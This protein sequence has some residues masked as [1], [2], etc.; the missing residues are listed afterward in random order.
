MDIVPELHIH[1]EGSRASL[2]WVVFHRA[3]GSLLI[4]FAAGPSREP[5]SIDLQPRD[6]Q[7]IVAIV[8]RG[9]GNKGAV[10]T[11]SFTLDSEIRSCDYGTN[12]GTLHDQLPYRSVV[13]IAV[14]KHKVRHPSKFIPHSY[15]FLGIRDMPAGKV[16]RGIPT[17]FPLCRHV[18]IP[19]DCPLHFMLCEVHLLSPTISLSSCAQPINPIN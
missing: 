16:C 14:G 10:G 11:W 4:L 9:A 15:L 6:L 18:D 13:A 8:H 7:M 17:G 19:S 12:T 2:G 1:L 5:S 3:P